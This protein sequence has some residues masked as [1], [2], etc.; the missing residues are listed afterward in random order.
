LSVDTYAIP[1]A[2]Q[3]IIYKP[4]RH[5]AF[6]G[7]TALVEYLRHRAEATPPAPSPELEQFLETVGFD[8]PM[9][10]CASVCLTEDA[11]H[12]TDVVLLMTNRCN[13]RCVYCY[14]N[15]GAEARVVEMQWPTAQAALDFALANAQ[16]E[17]APAPA[18]TFHGG[19]EPTVLWD[20]MVRAV[21]Y[22]RARDPRT[23][24]S[25]SSN[26]VWSPAQ[27][28]YICTHFNNVSVSMD[29]DAPVQNR[30]RPRAGGG[31]SFATVMESIAALDDAQVDYGIRMTVL[32][33]SVTALPDGVRFICEHT[34][35][36]TIQV[37]PTFTSSRG[38]YGDLDADF[39]DAFAERFMEAWA[40]GRDAGRRVYYSG[41]RPWVI[42]PMFCQAPLKAAVVT[43]DGRLVT[44]FEVFS[45][46]SPMANSFT[47]GRV[48]DGQVIY[49]PAA[50]Q[51]FLDAQQARRQA[52]VGC[53][54]YWHCCGDCATRRPEADNIDSGRCRVTR[55]ITLSLLLTFLEEGEGIWQ[56]LRESP[57]PQPPACDEAGAGEES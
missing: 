47:V 19:G 52:C 44:C 16:R 10:D 18:L 50:L 9:L 5:L 25:M 42:A 34:G 54:C 57:L 20:L 29:G 37:E 39:A 8:R 32:P 27:R 55:S 17:G 12:P 56:G 7:N 49:D 46:Q 33:D 24:L 11:L 35:A 30:Q 43:A 26:A 48:T 2:G 14:A 13:L 31:E 15:A 1:F 51:A 4:R 6:V 3:M 38:H 40:V 28:D 45:E 41:A 53:F 23:Q 22:A 21:D 36:K